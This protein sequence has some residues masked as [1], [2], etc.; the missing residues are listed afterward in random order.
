MW[1]K[2]SKLLLLF[3]VLLV[4][5]FSVYS[6][7]EPIT[8]AELQAESRETLIQIILIYDQSLTMS[9]QDAQEIETL[10][11]NAELILQQDVQR[12]NER[13]AAADRLVELLRI[14]LQLQKEKEKK[15]LT[16]HVL[17]GFGSAF[18]TYIILSI[19]GE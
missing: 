18:V 1:L 5:P 10:W 4:L 19:R 9:E 6:Q 13:E 7:D 15:I 14:S 8:A 17:I 16:E 3:L 2:L 12:A 11:N